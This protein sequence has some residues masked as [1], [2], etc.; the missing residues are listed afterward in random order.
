MKLGVFFIFCNP[1]AS[2]WVQNS[3]CMLV[4]FCLHQ[5]DL[6][7]EKWVV[8]AS[9]EVLLRFP[10]LPGED[11]TARC[12]PDKKCQPLVHKPHGAPQRPGVQEER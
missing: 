3:D 11:P 1:K 12:V 7:T 2:S 4:L 5:L 9:V 8:D 10:L 6:M